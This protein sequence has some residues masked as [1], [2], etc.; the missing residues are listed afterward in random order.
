MLFMLLE[1]RSGQPR[2]GLLKGLQ[3]RYKMINLNDSTIQALLALWADGLDWIEIDGVCYATF[4]DGIYTVTD[5][6]LD[7]NSKGE[8]IMLPDQPFGCNFCRC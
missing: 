7:D 1:L 2:A 8:F 6:V 3:M 4:H 5:C